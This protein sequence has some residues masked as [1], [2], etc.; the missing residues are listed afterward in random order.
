MRGADELLTKLHI[1]C[2]IIPARAGSS[3]RWTTCCRGSWDH[4][5]ACGEQWKPNPWMTTPQGSS[6]RVRG[7]EALYRRPR[8]SVGII[9]ARAGSSFRGCVPRSGSWDHPRACG[10]Q[11]PR[12]LYSSGWTG[13]S[14]RVRGAAVGHARRDE[15]AGIIPARAGSSLAARRSP[16]AARD[17]PRACGEQSVAVKVGKTR[18]GSSPRVRG[19]GLVRRRLV[20]WRGI[21]PAR[22]G[23]SRPPKL[24]RG[25]SRDHPRACGEQARWRLSPPR[26]SGSS[27]RVRG[28]AAVI[29]KVEVLVGIIPARAG[30]SSRTWAA[31]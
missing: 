21:I 30:S 23:S 1:V 18:Q 19:A 3:P 16:R 25:R 31:S 14:P 15:R 22:A 5:R 4:P 7:A 12:S 13:S 11:Q 28:A 24:G 27:P 29:W 8:L 2:G 26:L 9:P 10:E 20:H 6:P 17:H